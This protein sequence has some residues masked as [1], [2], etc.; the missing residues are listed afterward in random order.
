ME[1]KYKKLN[2]SKE[3]KELFNRMSDWLEEIRK[4][5]KTGFVWSMEQ[6]LVFIEQEIDRA[7][8]EGWLAGELEVISK[9]TLDW[10]DGDIMTTADREGNV[11]Q[12]VLKEMKEP[13]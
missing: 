2:W 11:H 3:R 10:K 4:G 8:E 9:T 13:N 7:R 5:E 1:K 6:L 12:F